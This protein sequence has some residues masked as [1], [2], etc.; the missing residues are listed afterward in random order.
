MTQPNNYP[1]YFVPKLSY[2]KYINGD[3][4]SNLLSGSSYL[5]FGT[6]KAYRKVMYTRQCAKFSK[7]RRGEKYYYMYTLKSFQTLF[8]DEDL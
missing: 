6:S 2:T 1:R 4:P 5:F 3:K 7:S 8:K